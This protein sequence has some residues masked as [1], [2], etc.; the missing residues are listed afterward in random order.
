MNEIS[1]NDTKQVVNK[2]ILENTVLALLKFAPGLGSVQINKALILIDA[3]Y[4]SFFKKTLTGITYIKHW[5]GPVPDHDAHSL[6]F[7]M[8]FSKIKVSHEKIGN[9]IKSAHYAICDPDYSLFSSKAIEIIRDVSMFIIQ[10]KAGNL[11]EITH[12]MVYENTPMGGVIPIESV[13]TLEIDSTPWT[14]EEVK[15]AI[16]I[17]EEITDSEEFDLSPFYSQN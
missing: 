11:S 8:E 4:H 7:K 16:T 13:Y 14:D 9:V 17:L 3:F 6:L 5:Y 2:E 1:Q 10:N 15:Q 12:D